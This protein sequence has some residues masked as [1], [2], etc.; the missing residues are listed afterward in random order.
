[1]TETMACPLSTQPPCYSV[2]VPA[3][4]AADTLGACL[5]ALLCQSLPRA[6][7]EVIVVDD[8]SS[9]AT[10]T[11]AGRYPVRVLC[12][13]HAGPAVARNRG[14]RVAK[15]E[16]LLF[17]DADCAPA[18]TWLAEIV[19]PLEG[20]SRVAGVKGVC[21]TAQAGLMARLGQ[22]E[23]EE[24]YA[25]LRQKP[26][27]DFVDT[28]SAAFRRD[29]FWEAGGFDPAFPEASNEDTALSF[30]LAERGWRLVFNDRALVE[31]HQP[32]SLGAYLRRKWRHG[33]WRAPVYR[34]FP[35]KLAGDSYTP[36]STQVQFAAALATLALLP[37]RRTRPWA[38]CTLLVFL[39]AALPFA[40]RALPSGGDVALAT[41]AILFLRS[42][43]LG[44]G[45]LGGALRLAVRAEGDNNAGGGAR[46][47]PVETDGSDNG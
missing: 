10:A 1:M 42:L 15:G 2:V 26:C 36:R 28:Y 11:V 45:L 8:G 39:G 25:R 18:P 14:A 16:Y 24:K 43:A 33:Y 31:H 35:G 23:L 22:V 9:D 19:R 13:A 17:T 27:I 4:N 29:A 46:P 34:R 47:R 12:Q 20:D 3:Y 44:L 32:D 21:R 7:Y 30:A 6:R 41:P 37:C 40:R 5:E 38:L